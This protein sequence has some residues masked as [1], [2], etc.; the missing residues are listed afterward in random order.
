[1]RVATEALSIMA[2]VGA[3]GLGAIEV[4]IHPDNRREAIYLDFNLMYSTN[5]VLASINSREISSTLGTVVRGR[6]TKRKY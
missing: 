3:V 1:M 2:L 6:C 5:V 4:T